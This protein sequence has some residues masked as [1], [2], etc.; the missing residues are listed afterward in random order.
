[1]NAETR[2]DDMSA[3]SFLQA[4]LWGMGVVLCVGGAA[5]GGGGQTGFLSLCVGGQGFQPKKHIA[6]TALRVFGRL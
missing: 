2:T 4:G 3:W 6:G 1:M 5:G